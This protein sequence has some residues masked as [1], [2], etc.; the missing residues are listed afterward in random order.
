MVCLALAVNESLPGQERVSVMVPVW[1][2]NAFCLHHSLMV[3]VWKDPEQTRLD[4]PR[5]T[6]GVALN[7][8]SFPLVLMVPVWN[9]GV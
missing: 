7:E 2:G 4:I 6:I 5:Q 3:S 8:M 9:E 1:V